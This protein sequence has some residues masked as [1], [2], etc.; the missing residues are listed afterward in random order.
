MRDVIGPPGITEQVL[1]ERADEVLLGEDGFRG[2]EVIAP[3]APL[4][5][6]PE[7]DTAL[8][9]L[10]AG[11]SNAAGV[12]AFSPETNKRAGMADKHPTIPDSTA[13]EDGIPVRPGWGSVKAQS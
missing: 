4:L 5:A 12:A 6:E 7:T 11:Q 2:R 13:V 3:A 9:F 10:I 8:V 1:R